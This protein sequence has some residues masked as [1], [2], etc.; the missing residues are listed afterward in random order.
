[1]IYVVTS[2]HPDCNY[3]QPNS[4]YYK[5]FEDSWSSRDL[6]ATWRP[7]IYEDLQIADSPRGCAIPLLNTIVRSLINQSFVEDKSI[8]VFSHDVFILRIACRVKYSRACLLGNRRDLAGH[9]ADSKLLAFFFFFFF[10]FLFFLL[11]QHS[12]DF[13]LAI[14]RLL[15][16]SRFL[17]VASF[18]VRSGLVSY[19][20]LANDITEEGKFFRKLVSDRRLFVTQPFSNENI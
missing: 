8:P 9:R 1:M 10:V 6:S 20:W 13:Y 12:R 7:G 4:L 2:I 17:R 11:F 3:T 16:D 14:N 5:Q 15:E 19:H 18:R